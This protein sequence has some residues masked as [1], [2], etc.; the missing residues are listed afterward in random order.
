MIFRKTEELRSKQELKEGAAYPLL[1]KYLKI[2]VDANKV[3]L[4]TV[5][6]SVIDQ[7]RKMPL[8]LGGK[9][10]LDYNHQFLE[11]H[12]N[13]LVHRYAGNLFHSFSFFFL[14]FFLLK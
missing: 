14:V 2:L 4:N 10:L 7:E 9:S 11:R 1:T 8:L 13:S 5:V 12:K 6:R 3:N